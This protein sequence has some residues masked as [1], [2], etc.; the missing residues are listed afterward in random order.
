MFYPYLIARRGHRQPEGYLDI[1]VFDKPRL[2]KAGL[3]FL[4]PRARMFFEMRHMDSFLR[5]GSQFLG[6]ISPSMT[7]RRGSPPNTPSPV[8]PEDN[9]IRRGNAQDPNSE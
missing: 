6:A 8:K 3:R 2:S 4:S 5:F 7:L 1:K 9:P